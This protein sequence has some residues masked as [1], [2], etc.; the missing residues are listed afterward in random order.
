M[1]LQDFAQSDLAR[2][3]FWYPDETPGPISELNQSGYIKNLPRDQLTP[4]FY[5]NGKHFFVNE[6]SQLSDSRL[7]IP[8]VWVTR[9]NSVY[10]YANVVHLVAQGSQVCTNIFD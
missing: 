5:T 4:S 9:Y 10:A 1:T 2:S 8:R 6:L 7:V 3:M